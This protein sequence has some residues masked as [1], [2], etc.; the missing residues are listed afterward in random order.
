M[1]RKDKLPELLAPAGSEEAFLAAL[2]AGADAIYLG[3]KAFNARAFA[4]NFDDETLARCVALA[5]AGGTRVYVT[6]N[7]LLYAPELA[8]RKQRCLRTPCCEC[9]RCMPRARAG[10][11]SR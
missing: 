1:R 11:R 9:T 2:A 7:T 3:G 8:A 4:E 5:H 6:L 10:R